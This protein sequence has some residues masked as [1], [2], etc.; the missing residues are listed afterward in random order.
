MTFLSLYIENPVINF[1]ATTTAFSLDSSVQLFCSA[2]GGYPLYYNI[3]LVK[4]NFIAASV[5]GTQLVHKTS[6]Y[7]LYICIIRNTATEVLDT[8]LLEEKS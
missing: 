6:M 7:G 1:T 2:S 5:I 4:N 3:S 8:L